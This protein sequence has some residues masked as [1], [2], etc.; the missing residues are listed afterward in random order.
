MAHKNG[1]Q[2]KTVRY[3]MV[4]SDK[5]SNSEWNTHTNIY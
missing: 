1:T 2:N 3:E 4:K 5:C